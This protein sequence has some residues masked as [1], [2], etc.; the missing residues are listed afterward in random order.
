LGKNITATNEPKRIACGAPDFIITRKNVP[1]GHVETK[2]VG[3]S[4]EEMEKGKGP[5][6]EQFKRYRDGLP[7]WIL[8]DYLDFHWYV[9][10]ERRL[11]ARLA[12]FDGKKKIQLL[13]TGEVEVTHILESFLLQSMPT[14]ESA[15][16]LADRMAGMT[17][18]LRS[19]I[20]ATFQHG[21]DNEQKQLQ[22]WLSAFKEV[23]IPNLVFEVFDDTS[24]SRSFSV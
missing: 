1:L 19:L 21:S 9:A 11:T 20:A 18:I 8:T 12:T 5:N 13:P 15:K 4:L 14:V 16:D 6:G 17:R 7:N 10:G 2:D 3:V 23:L 22:N 24:R